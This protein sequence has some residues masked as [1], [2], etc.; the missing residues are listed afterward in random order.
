M[1]IIHIETDIVRLRFLRS[2]EFQLRDVSRGQ[3]DATAGRHRKRGRQQLFALVRLR[4]R[5]HGL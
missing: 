1:I 3:S 4:G 5:G 2:A